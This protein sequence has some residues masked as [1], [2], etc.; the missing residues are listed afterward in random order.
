[1]KNRALLGGDSFVAMMQAPDL[2]NRYNRPR[3]L[4]LNAPLKRRIL[5]QREVRAGA[6]IIIEVRFQDAPQTGLIQD[7]HVIQ[8]F[9]EESS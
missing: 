8:A 6:H 1:M 2:G 9:P 7:D 5:A 4:R 3:P